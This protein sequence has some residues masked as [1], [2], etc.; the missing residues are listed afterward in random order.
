MVSLGSLFICLQFPGVGTGQVLTVPHVFHVPKFFMRNVPIILFSK[1]PIKTI[2]TRFNFT[3]VVLCVR[4][5][6][7]TITS[8]P[9]LQTALQDSHTVWP[10]QL[11]PWSPRRVSAS[12]LPCSRSTSAGSQSGAGAFRSRASAASSAAPAARRADRHSS[13]QGGS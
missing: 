8:L 10:R 3:K 6:I 5:C 9:P 12:T 7:A 2:F 4:K 1:H 13:S 11:S